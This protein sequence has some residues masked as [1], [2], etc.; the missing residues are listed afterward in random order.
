MSELTDRQLKQLWRHSIPL[1]SAPVYFAH[2]DKKV[3]HKTANSVSA[4]DAFHEGMA[5]AQTNNKTGHDAFFTAFEGP[6][7]ILVERQDIMRDLQEDIIKWGRTDILRAVAFQP[8]RKLE[9]VPVVV[10]KSAWNGTFKW[11]RSQVNFQS[12]EFIEVRVTTSKIWKQVVEKFAFDTKQKGRPSMQ[13]VLS[14]V[15]NEL[16]REGNVDLSRSIASHIPIIRKSVELLAKNQKM[17]K[18]VLGDETIRKAF[19]PI[20]K[21][22]KGSRKL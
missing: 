9:D 1:V 10:P 2:P 15:I 18:T 12:I 17:Q 5:T 22:L 21:G 3:C 14:Q 4:I 13:H 8:P 11:E 19:S 7:R 20:F 6:Q 16:V